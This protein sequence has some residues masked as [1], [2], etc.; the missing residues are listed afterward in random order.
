MDY[1]RIMAGG[2]PLSTDAA[3]Q[4]WRLAKHS[5]WGKTM[6]DDEQLLCQLNFRLDFLCREINLSHKCLGV[7]GRV[8]TYPAQ[9]NEDFEQVFALQVEK[10]EQNFG[11]HSNVLLKCPTLL[12]SSAEK[13]A[14]EFDS[15]NQKLFY[16]REN[17]GLTVSDIN[18][19][20]YP[21]NYSI[22]DNGSENSLPYKLKYYTEELGFGKKEFRKSPAILSLNCTAGNSPTSV[23]NKV[24]FLRDYTGIG[25]KQL[26]NSPILLSM[27]CDPNSVSPSAIINKI[28]TLREVFGLNENAWKSYPVLLMMDCDP[29][30]NSPTSVVCKMN[31]FREKLGFDNIQINAYP[32]L[33]GMDCSENSTNPASIINKIK[34][35]QDFGI[36]TD[37]LKKYVNLLGYDCDP[38][39]KNESSVVGKIKVLDELG[40][41]RDIVRQMPILLGMPA[42]KIKIRYMLY[43]TSALASIGLKSAIFIQNEAKTYARMNYLQDIGYAGNK[44]AVIFPEH[45]FV[46]TFGKTSAMLMDIYPLDE[47]AIHSVEENFTNMVGT[48]IRL[49]DSELGAVCQREV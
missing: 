3:Q 14:M 11:L 40:L 28:K 19:Y 29:N 21:L 25:E 37:D 27:D 38:N 12:L 6:E 23:P 13:G 43:K 15:I 35:Y 9:T 26:R 18:K 31:F 24:K 33:L 10:F 34:F 4:I 7:F 32:Q 5:S 8:I 16:I 39:S 2:Q 49:N 1:S 41:E 45:R 20:P 44:Q 47:T 17:F 22:V 48:D 46:K 36:T 42:N 30:S